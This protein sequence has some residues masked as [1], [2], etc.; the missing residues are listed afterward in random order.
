[1]TLNETLFQDT[2]HV[3]LNKAGHDKRTLRMNTGLSPD[4]ETK[5]RE[6]LLSRGSARRVPLLI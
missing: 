6:L 1:M 5:I 4:F 3:T 2:L